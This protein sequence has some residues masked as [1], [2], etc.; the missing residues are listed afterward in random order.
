V[1][2]DNDVR[3]PLRVLGIPDMYLQSGKPD[4]LAWHRRTHCRERRRQDA[5]GV[6]EE[7]G[8]L[9]EQ[10]TRLFINAQPSRLC[11]PYYTDFRAGLK[12]RRTGKGRYIAPYTR[13]TIPRVEMKDMDISVADGVL[14]Y[15]GR[16]EAGRGD[17]EGRLLSL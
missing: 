13:A 9:A 10:A 16:E 17:Q 6:G 15:Q 4:E 3:V 5:R 11:H 1:L 2:A 12:P 8:L 7:I 14:N